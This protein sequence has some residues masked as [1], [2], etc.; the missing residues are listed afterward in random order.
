MKHPSR[1]PYALRLLACVAADLIIWALP[2]M[3]GFA[4]MKRVIATAEF[5][6]GERTA[7]YLLWLFGWS[8]F[9][10]RTVLFRVVEPYFQVK[11]LQNPFHHLF[12]PQPASF[13]S[14]REWWN[15]TFRDTEDEAVP[16]SVSED[17]RSKSASRSRR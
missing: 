13:R 6:D 7:F 12:R 15:W 17:R 11:S 10:S 16:A 9:I 4:A 5:S 8:I 3:L 14:F 2:L 1:W